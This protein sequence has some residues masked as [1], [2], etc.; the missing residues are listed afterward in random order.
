WTVGSLIETIRDILRRAYGTEPTATFWKYRLL[1]AGIDIL[2]VVLLLLSLI[3]QVLIGAAQEVI[4]SYFPELSDILGA[5][6]LSR[7][8][9]GL[10]LFGSLYLLL[11]TLTPHAYRNRRYPKWPGVLL[12][13]VW[14]ILV[15]LS[16]PPLLRTVFSYDLT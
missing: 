13:T 16:L 6:S 4:E 12:V 3:A 9:P 10:G 5:L 7:L 14:W 15:T 8:L 1:S 2:A 11:Y